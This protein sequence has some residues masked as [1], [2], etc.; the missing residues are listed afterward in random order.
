MHSLKIKTLVITGIAT[1]ICVDPTARDGFMRDT[2][3]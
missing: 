3:S 1:N 2:T